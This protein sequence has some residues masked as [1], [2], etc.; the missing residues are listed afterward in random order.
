MIQVQLPLRTRSPDPRSSISTKCHTGPATV[1]TAR[2]TGSAVHFTTPAWET[3]VPDGWR[4]RPRQSLVDAL[5]GEGRSSRRTA[6][7][8]TH[9][10]TLAERLWRRRFAAF[11]RW[12]NAIAVVAVVLSLPALWYVST[13]Q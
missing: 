8:R 12:L 1:A 10:S 4:S 6:A 9:P 7:G 11:D 5:P 2:R 13:L 3:L